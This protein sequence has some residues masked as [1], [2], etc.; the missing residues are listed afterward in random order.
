MGRWF[1]RTQGEGIFAERLISIPALW[2]ESGNR[3]QVLNR[4]FAVQT[5]P[6]NAPHKA[7]KSGLGIG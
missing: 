4:E 7:H 2:G 3:G 5:D 1:P 6:L